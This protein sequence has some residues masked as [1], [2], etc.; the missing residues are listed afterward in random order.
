MRKLLFIIAISSELCSPNLLQAAEIKEQLCAENLPESTPS[1]HFIVQPGSAT[2][3]H[4]TT[5]LIWHRCLLG[6]QFEQGQCS[7]EPIVFSQRNTAGKIL[8][9]DNPALSLEQELLKTP[10]WRIANEKEQLSIV[11]YRCVF[12]RLNTEIF[13]GYRKSFSDNNQI[14]SLSDFIGNKGVYRLVKD[15]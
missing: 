15:H 9:V 5:N 14:F 12:P 7:G 3:L 13:P 8:A 11:E 6:Q 2:V 10:G 1:E 4:K